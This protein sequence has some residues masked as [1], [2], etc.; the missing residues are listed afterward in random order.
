MVALVFLANKVWLERRAPR[1]LPAPPAD[2]DSR[3]HVVSRETGARMDQQDQRVSGA[4]MV[5][6]DSPALQEVSEIPDHPDI[7]ECQE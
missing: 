4:L 6:Q 7:Q 1:D 2:Q 3:D 5:Y